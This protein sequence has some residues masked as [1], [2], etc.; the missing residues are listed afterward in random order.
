MIRKFKTEP[1]TAQ[2]LIDIATRLAVELPAKS[3]ERYDR[4][5][6]LIHHWALWGHDPARNVT[7]CR[8]CK[9]KGYR[10]DCHAAGWFPVACKACNGTGKAVKL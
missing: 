1:A 9:G 7:T 5:E 3:V 6:L 2:G 10:Y 4:A 8:E